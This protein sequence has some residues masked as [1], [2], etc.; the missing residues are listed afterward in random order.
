[1][2]WGN[3]DWGNVD[4]GNVDWG[5][6]DWVMWTG[7]MWTGGNVDWGVMWIGVGPLGAGVGPLGAG[8]GPLGAG[9]HQVSWSASDDA[10]CSRNNAGSCPLGN[11]DSSHQPRDKRMEAVTLVCLICNH[12][13][14]N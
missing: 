9:S 3:V 7:A 11:S 14:L 13:H 8:V 1:M 4:W 12:M 10:C 5:N 2:D 6:V